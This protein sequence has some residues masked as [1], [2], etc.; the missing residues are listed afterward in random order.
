[1]NVDFADCIHFRHPIE[2]GGLYYSLTLLQAQVGSAVCAK[3]YVDASDGDAEA[4]A[5]ET[6]YEF[7]ATVSATWACSYVLFFARIKKSYAGTFIDTRSAI[8]YTVDQFSDPKASDHQR[9]ARRYAPR[10]CA[11]REEK[12]R[13]TNE[14]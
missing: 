3:L 8:Q 5:A 6:V 13:Q 11:G 4:L 10:T 1:M 9:A 2:L 7:T 14:Q 12:R